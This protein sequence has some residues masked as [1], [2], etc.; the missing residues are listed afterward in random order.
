MSTN[1]A[2]LWRMGLTGAA[3]LLALTA[4]AA[5]L[6]QALLPAMRWVCAQWVDEFRILSFSLDREGAD[7]VLRAV[8]KVAR[9]TVVHGRALTPEGGGL[10]NASTMA[11]QGLHSSFIALWVALAWPAP[12][13]LLTRVKRVALLAVPALALL[14]V[15]APTVVAGSLWQIVIDALAPGSFSPLLTARTVLQEGGRLVL[16]A[17]LGAAAVALIRPLDRVGAGDKARRLNTDG[18]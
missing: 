18:Q 14:I 13:R 11:W 4:F 1:T 15:D 6:L 16:G 8:V 10:A 2:L 17:A 7:S 3:L 9:H 12:D 5:P